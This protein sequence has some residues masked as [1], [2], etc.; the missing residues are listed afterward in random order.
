MSKSQNDLCLVYINIVSSPNKSSVRTFQV[1]Q[2]SCQ[3]K[4]P[5]ST[6]VILVITDVILYLTEWGNKQT[7]KK[8]KKK[9]NQ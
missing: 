2:C 7:K 6:I 5:N 1:H 3:I 4:I 8:K 9:K